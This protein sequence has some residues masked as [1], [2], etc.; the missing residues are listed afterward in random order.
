MADEM[1]ALMDGQM[2]ACW[3]IVT[4]VQMER[5]LVDDSAD[6]WVGAMEW[7]MAAYLV[8]VTAV[9]TAALMVVC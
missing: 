4:V 9:S 2:D 8:D 1:V 7:L 6:D 3:D 5:F